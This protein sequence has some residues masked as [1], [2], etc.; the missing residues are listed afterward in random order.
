[1]SKKTKGSN[2]RAW[3]RT[4]NDRFGPATEAAAQTTGAPALYGPAA[5]DVDEKSAVHELEALGVLVGSCVWTA[6]QLPARHETAPKTGGN[7]PFMSF[8]RS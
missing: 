7:G 8:S 6:R 2:V 4:S 3:R 1:M 5:L